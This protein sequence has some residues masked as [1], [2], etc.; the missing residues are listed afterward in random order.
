MTKHLFPYQE[1][2]IEAIRE[3]YIAGHRSPIL[4]APTGSGKTFMAATI[5]K[6]AIS[7]GKT[8]WFL[9]HL[10]EILE[11]T[12]K[13]LESQLIDFGFIAAGKKMNL[14]KSVQLVMVQ[15]AARRELGVKPDLVIIDECHLAVASTYKNVLSSAGN[16]IVL[17]LTGTPRRLDGRGLGEVFD[18]I[19]LSKST[20][21]LIEMEKLVPV[22]YYAPYVPELRK[23]RVNRGEYAAEQL[24]EIMNN[25][26]IT[27]DAISHYRKRCAGK[28]AVVF[29]VNVNHSF[30]VAKAFRDAG[31][32]AV[33]ISGKSSK[34]ER[35]SAISGLRSGSIQVVCN[36]QLWVAGVDIPAIS[37]VI[38]LRP[39]KSLTFYL[40]AVGRGLRTCP[41]K[42]HLTV[43]D[44]SAL[45]FTH[46]PPDMPREWSLEA[47]PKKAG[48]APLTTC[49]VCYAVH[50]VSK[51]CPEC[52]HVYGDDDQVREL[53]L[54]S[55]E[56]EE[57]TPED[58]EEIERLKSEKQISK[59]RKR[60]ENAS[61]RT[62]EQL[63][64]LGR[65]RGYSYPLHWARRV[66][67]SR[68]VKRK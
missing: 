17:G 31:F 49:P 15:S 52:G 2:A 23:V 56:L 9:A 13:R 58:V 40:Q 46:G 65:S 67:D 64:A 34:A 27:G 57:L 1:Q 14:L 35:D 36:C 44:H 10:K 21:E 38:F 39:S 62:E 60:Q 66:M 28:P 7:K 6:S 5:I 26:S 37:C 61:A 4:C 11:D 51:V 19:I 42:R 47:K 20:R 45:I 63:V 24:E 25:P 32:S 53:P 22:K 33:S 50:Y 59:K 12:A 3:S 8:V 18:D 48:L 54:R 68:A 43:L 16:P 30:N 41:G 55:G 29:C